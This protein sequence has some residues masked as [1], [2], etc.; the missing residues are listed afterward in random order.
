MWET[1]WDV[2]ERVCRSLLQ[3]SIHIYTSLFSYW[4][5][6]PSWRCLWDYAWRER[7]YETYATECVGLFCR[8]LFTYVRLFPHIGVETNVGGVCGTLLN[9]RDCI[10][11]M[12]ESVQVSFTGLYSHVYVAFHIMCRDQCWRSVWDH[13]RCERLYLTYVK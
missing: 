6:G 9:G 3:V 7:L 1:L 4:R 2:R 10:W 12:W 8:S 11:R 13:I 5:R